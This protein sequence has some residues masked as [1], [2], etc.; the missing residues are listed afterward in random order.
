MDNTNDKQPDSPSS[1]PLLA[2]V[3]GSEAIPQPNV[4]QEGRMTRGMKAAGRTIPPVATPMKR[5]ARAPKPIIIKKKE[6]NVLDDTS[7]QGTA[8]LKKTK[9]PSLDPTD[10]WACGPDGVPVIDRIVCHLTRGYART[11]REDELSEAAHKFKWRA[12]KRHSLRDLK[13][14]TIT[15]KHQARKKLAEN[16]G[17]KLQQIKLDLL[18]VITAHITSEYSDAMYA[19]WREGREKVKMN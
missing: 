10:P 11:P 13:T 3:T 16:P 15:K 19:K 17:D 7:S 12:I 2:V 18:K 8:N 6:P 5:K 1:I 4:P 9:A 14:I